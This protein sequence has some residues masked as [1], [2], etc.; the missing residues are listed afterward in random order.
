MNANR[1]ALLCAVLATSC[2]LFAGCSSDPASTSSSTSVPPNGAGAGPLIGQVAQPCVRDCDGKA[3]GFDGC[4]AQC[5]ICSAGQACLEDQCVAYQCVPNCEGRVCGNDG[6][7]GSCGTCSEGTFCLDLVGTCNLPEEPDTCQG[8][9]YDGCCDGETATWCDGGALVTEDCGAMS[10]SCGWVPDMGYY[11]QSDGGVDPSGTLPKD[12]PAL[13]D[14]CMG[15]TYDG[16]CDG[17]VATWCDEGAL[18]TEDCSAMSGSCGWDPEAGYYCETDG[19]VD[20]S[21]ELPKDCGLSNCTPNCTGAACGDDGCGGTCG[22]CE[23]GL[24]CELGV[25]V[26]DPCLG[27]GPD[28]CCDGQISTWCENDK[29]VTEDCSGQVG[30]C[31]WTADSGYYCQSGG[32]TDPGGLP[33]DCGFGDP[34]ADPCEGYSAQGCCQGQTVF[35]CEDDAVQE[36][37]CNPDGGCGWDTATG[38]Y[39]CGTAGAQDPSGTHLK[40]CP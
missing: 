29:L 24:S 11:C 31:G 13:T 32:G 28:G 21:G 25:C 19:G 16:C 35:W 9:T 37:D 18:K 3:C 22:T 10:G 14:S 39:D 30:S 5:G 36:F 1:L 8:I 38:A 17:E 7:G 20:P 2:W 6:C 27:I 34:P 15:I 23:A 33:K 4:F 26:V 40:D 12:C